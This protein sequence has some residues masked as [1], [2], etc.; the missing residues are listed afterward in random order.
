MPLNAASLPPGFSW[1]NPD[2]RPSPAE[3]NAYA[4]LI[5]SAEGHSPRMAPRLRD[6]AELQLWI[7]R[8]ENNRLT[9]RH[10]PVR[11]DLRTRRHVA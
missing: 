6:E 9:R 5:A 4:H 7:W 3:I 1:L 2:C 8:S 10:P 11:S